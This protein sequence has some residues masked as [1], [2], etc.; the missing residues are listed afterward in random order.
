MNIIENRYTYLDLLKLE[1]NGVLYEHHES[2]CR[3]YISRKLALN[4][5]PVYPYTGRFGKGFR[6]LLP[7]WESTNYIRVKYFIYKEEKV[8]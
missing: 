4:E 5:L 2:T 7:N 1:N 6:V 3:G 8:L